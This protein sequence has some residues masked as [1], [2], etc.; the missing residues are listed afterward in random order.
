[1]NSTEIM[2]LTHDQIPGY[3][4]SQVTLGRDRATVIKEIAALRSDVVL[5]SVHDDQETF[6]AK[7]KAACNLAQ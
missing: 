2:Y 3:V 5:L 4:E 7:V 6:K 1:M